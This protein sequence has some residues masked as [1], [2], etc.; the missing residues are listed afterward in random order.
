MKKSNLLLSAVIAAALGLLL[1]LS[2]FAADE[3]KDAGKDKETAKN[4]TPINKN[5]PVEGGEIDAKEFVVYKGKKVA[6]CCSGCDK[7]FNKDPEKFMKLLADKGD[8]NTIKKPA[9]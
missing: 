4:L 2:A 7:E 1:G 3:K 5:C 9:K 8:D 6:F